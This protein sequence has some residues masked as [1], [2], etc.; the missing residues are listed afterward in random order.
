MQHITVN[1][2]HNATRDIPRMYLF[3]NWKFVPFD[4][5]HLFHPYPIPHLCL[6]SVSNKLGSFPPRFHM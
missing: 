5:F 6:L 3:Y 2:S 1:C 4:P